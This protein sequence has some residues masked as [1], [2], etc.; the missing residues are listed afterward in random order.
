MRAE[1][2]RERPDAVRQDTNRWHE[3]RFAARRR[4]HLTERAAVVDPLA[5]GGSRATT[6]LLTHQVGNPGTA[7]SRGPDC[8]GLTCWCL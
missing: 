4:H 5:M 3:E 8:F 2:D 1:A 7:I 6:G